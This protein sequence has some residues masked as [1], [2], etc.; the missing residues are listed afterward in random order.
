MQLIACCLNGRKM[1]DVKRDLAP[2]SIITP[3]DFW[4]RTAFLN[5]VLTLPR[6][7]CCLDR[8]LIH[9]TMSF[10]ISSLTLSQFG[11]R[12]WGFKAA[13]RSPIF[14]IESDSLTK[15]RLEGDVLQ[16]ARAHV[17]RLL[18]YPSLRNV[19]RDETPPNTTK[20]SPNMSLSRRLGPP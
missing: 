10:K 5:G 13:L 20:P 3:S 9:K 18:I 17:S 19:P 8:G 12:V 6:S 1:L 7:A 11:R 15:W 16:R 4:R 14:R 2:V